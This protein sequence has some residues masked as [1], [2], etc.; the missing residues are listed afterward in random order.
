MMTITTLVFFEMGRFSLLGGEEG[1]LQD[2]L[3]MSM[4][5]QSA[6]I[7]KVRRLPR[8]GGVL[9]NDIGDSLTV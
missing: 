6:R 8:R 3:R 1:L 2:T 9:I 5:R 4:Q 7:G